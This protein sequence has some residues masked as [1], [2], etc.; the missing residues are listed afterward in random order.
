MMRSDANRFSAATLLAPA[1]DSVRVAYAG[2]Y[3]VPLV[4]VRLDIIP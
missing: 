1:A 2:S 3:S 4:P